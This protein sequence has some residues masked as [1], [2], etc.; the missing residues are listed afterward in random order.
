MLWFF[1]SKR[2]RQLFSKNMI[3]LAGL[4]VSTDYEFLFGYDPAGFR[5]DHDTIRGVSG[6]RVTKTGAIF[7]GEINKLE[8]SR[9]QEQFDNVRSPFSLGTFQFVTVRE[10]GWNV[11]V[12]LCGQANIFCWQLGESY[13]LSNDVS[14]I[15]Q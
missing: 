14:L 6:A 1:A 12:D 7:Q 8:L 4:S 11:D 5:R 2:I 10:N 9:V 13:V 3:S 15:L